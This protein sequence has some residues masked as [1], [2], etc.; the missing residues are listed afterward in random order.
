MLTWMWS[1]YSIEALGDHYRNYCTYVLRD[2]RRFYLHFYD[3]RVLAR[4]RQVWTSEEQKAFVMPCAEIWYSDRMQG[5]VVWS[6]ESVA[7]QSAGHLPQSLTL[8]QHQLL[9]DLA[10]PD[11]LVLH[12]RTTCGASLDHLTP[13]ELHRLICSQLERAGAYRI[14]SESDLLNYV[15]YG[16]LIAP[17]FDEHPLIH[18]RLLAATRGDV[19]PTDALSG[20]TDDVWSA[21]REGDANA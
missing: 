6:N 10:Y 3:N 21:I 18:D 5:D 19:S 12:L 16:V 11:K 4:L 8:Q 15:T 20:V 1:P 7:L 2:K 14:N 13:S 9:I 17:T